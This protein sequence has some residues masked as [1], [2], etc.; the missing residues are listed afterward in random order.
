MMQMRVSVLDA[1]GVV[2]E[3]HLEK[4]SGQNTGSQEDGLRRFM[5]MVSVVVAVM[6]IAEYFG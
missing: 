1:F 5:G 2:I 4:E 3:D 6:S